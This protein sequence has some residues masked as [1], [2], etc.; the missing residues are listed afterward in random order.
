MD[1]YVF[2]QVVPGQVPG[3]LTALASKQGVRRAVAVVGGW[4]VLLHAEGPDLSTIAGVILSELH[5]VPGVVRTATAP[6]VPADRIGI[7]GFGGPQPPPIVPEACYVQ[8]AAEPGAA[9]GI[10]EHLAEIGDIAGVAVTGG[11]WDLLT[12]VA[13]PWEIASGTIVERI[14]TIPGVRRT[15]TLVS[16]AYEEPEEDRDQFSS[17]S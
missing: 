12:C 13:Q 16:L 6:V 7:T 2:L 1:A 11:E 5:N 10:A 3:V 4:D 8:I 14:Q 17:W 15:S 9:A